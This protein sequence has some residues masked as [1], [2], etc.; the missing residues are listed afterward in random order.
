MSADYTIWLASPTGEHLAVLDSYIRLEYRRVVNATGLTRTFGRFSYPLKLDLAHSHLPRWLVGLLRCDYR[1]EV[2][3]SVGGG[4]LELDTATV[5]L[6][7]R[8]E[9]RVTKEGQRIVRVEA[10]PAMA[11]LARRI[12]A[13]AAE[14]SQASKQG[15]A[16]DIMR[17][18]VREN[19]GEGAT[20]TPRDVSAWLH[21]PPTSDDCSLGAV[22]QKSFA[23][24][25][26]LT[27]LQEIAEASTRA[28]VPLFF[29]VVAPT[30]TQLVFATFAYA[31]G[32]DHRYNTASAAMPV[33]L[34]VETGTLTDVVR[35]SDWHD[36]VTHVYV[37]GQ[38]AHESREV[39]TVGD[40]ARAAALPFG[41]R[42]SLEDARHVATT[43]NLAAEGYAMLRNRQRRD[44]FQAVV[45][46]RKP[47]ALYGVHWRVGDLVSVEFEGEALACQIDSIHIVV[48]EGREHITATLS[49]LE[50]RWAMDA[51]DAE[52]GATRD[53]AV[54]TEHVLQQV[55][56]KSVPAGEYV[57]IP[58]GGQVVVYGDYALQGTLEIAAG[59]ELRLLR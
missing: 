45:V 59:G 42:E 48:E 57:H 2:W 6:I 26:V 54:E 10:E 5:W 27:V 40:E 47:G 9:R 58:A 44:E 55:Q 50:G 34:S 24:R 51:A 31:R 17:E 37:A 29:D 36:E 33:V 4:L 38:G 8:V 18:V 7:S 13:Y 23:R 32:T 21:I 16:D 12:V 22:V 28:G 20:T 1:L 11:L 53:R 30:P 19:F 52:A 39:V 56:R 46:S 14:S 49:L 3:R 41:R 15:Y 35:A 43:S 25:N